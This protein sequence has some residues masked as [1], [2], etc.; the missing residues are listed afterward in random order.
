M[1]TTSTHHCEGM[2]CCHSN[3]MRTKEGGGVAGCIFRRRG[4]KREVVYLEV[5]VGGTRSYFGCAE[6][7][8]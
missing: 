5:K 7:G 4:K 8:M 3:E 2:R 6:M 1:V